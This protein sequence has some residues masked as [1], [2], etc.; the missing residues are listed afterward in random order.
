[1]NVYLS[2]LEKNDKIVGGFL[3]TKQKKWCQIAVSIE[4][5]TTEDGN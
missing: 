2:T 5:I 4:R 3:K 1:M